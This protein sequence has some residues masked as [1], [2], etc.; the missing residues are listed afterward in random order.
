MDPHPVS[1]NCHLFD[2]GCAN[3]HGLQVYLYEMGRI[4]T[5]DFN[6]VSQKGQTHRF[7]CANGLQD[8]TLDLPPSG[9]T[10]STAEDSVSPHVT[11]DVG[12]EAQA[13]EMDPDSMYVS[14]FGFF[15]VHWHNVVFK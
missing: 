6:L 13:R 8:F 4:P 14:N 12:M 1:P 11:I 7:D 10:T 5:V 2:C 15:V 3:G 9:S